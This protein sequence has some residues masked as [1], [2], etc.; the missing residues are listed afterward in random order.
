[1]TYCQTPR[2]IEVQMT[3]DDCRYISDVMTCHRNGLVQLMFLSVMDSRED[4]VKGSTPYI[5]VVCAGS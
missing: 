1:M 4:I 5:G 2:V 3:N